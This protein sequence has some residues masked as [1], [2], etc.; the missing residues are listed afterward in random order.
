MFDA[1]V[2]VNSLHWI[3]PRLRFAKPYGLL[4]SGG[5][6]AVAG[7]LRAQPAEAERF[8]ADV[9]ADLTF[10]GYL[11]VGRRAWPGKGCAVRATSGRR[12]RRCMIGYICAS[13]D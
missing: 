3:D 1:V 11:T 13:R 7:C 10:A 9:Q 12:D 5:V 6:M 8:W 2:A 4:R